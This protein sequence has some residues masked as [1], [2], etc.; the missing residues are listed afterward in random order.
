MVYDILPTTNLK[1]E[2]IRDT[3]NADGG[4]V[5][6]DVASAFKGTANINKWSRHKP[7]R[8]AVN[9]C[10]DFD[11]SAPNYDAE[12]WKGTSRTFG[13]KIPY[14]SATTRLNDEAYKIINYMPG[15]LPNYI[16]ELPR[17]GE[18]EPLRI[19][20]FAGY[21]KDAG[22]PFTTTV[23]G[24]PYTDTPAE[25]N[26]F[27]TNKLL[28]SL[29]YEPGNQDFTIMDFLQG[30]NDYYLVVEFYK[31][32]FYQG[33]PFLKIHSTSPITSTSPVTVS[34]DLDGRFS[35][36]GTTTAIMGVQR[37]IDSEYISE[38]TFFPPWIDTSGSITGSKKEYPFLRYFSF[39]NYFDRQLY[40]I[41][42]R[43]NRVDSTEYLLPN[44]DYVVTFNSSLYIKFKMSRD[45]K[46]LL[47]VSNETSYS[48]SGVSK[49]RF[50]A[51]TQG[52]TTAITAFGYP[53]VLNS[54]D[55][56]LAST[57]YIDVPSGDKDE[58][59]EFYLEF[60]NLLLNNGYVNSLIIEV[61]IDNGSTWVNAS[62]LSVYLNVRQ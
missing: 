33:N 10:Q 22:I 41:S 15:M 28:F 16:Y 50:R 2:D 8:L 49:I 32:P 45:E 60:R 55:N 59:T 11:S 31:D 12:W 13:L 51:K 5:N 52:D 38:G 1:Y 43:L 21:K 48:P 53:M 62:S 9:F 17:G 46:R 37:M 40:G 61:S 20:D 4:F 6:N 14:L 54:D 3:L 35:G 26:M 30:R 24:Y 27:S 7:V 36:G 42:M 44:L 34:V 23:S 57:D 25:V 18:S 58:Y 29:Y 19:G 47:V 56:Y 39:V